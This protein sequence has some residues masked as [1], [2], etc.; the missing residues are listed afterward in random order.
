MRKFGVICFMIAMAFAVAC[1]G[2][3]ENVATSMA[4]PSGLAAEQLD[5]T[6]VKLTWTDNAE[7]ESG[8]WIFRRSENDNYYVEPLTKLGPDATS[9]TFS[10]LTPGAEYDFGVQALSSDMKY[11]SKIV[12]LNDFKVVDYEKMP[13]VQT[14]NSTYAFL[15]IGSDL[16]Y[17]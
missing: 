2:K 10:G 15:R 11:H 16:S 12:Y 4:D 13:Q 3:D 6:T 17:H 14:V 9:Y 5:L 1:E 8:Y 7:G